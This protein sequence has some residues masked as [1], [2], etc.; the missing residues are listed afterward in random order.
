MLNNFVILT[1]EFKNRLQELTEAAQ[2]RA[3]KLRKGDINE[4]N[5]LQR[6]CESRIHSIAARLSQ[7]ID[8]AQQKAEKTR[9]SMIAEL[10]AGQAD[11]SNLKTQTGTDTDKQS[12][13]VSTRCLWNPFTWFNSPETVSYTVTRNYEYL[14]TADAI[15]QVVNYSRE[16]AARMEY[17]FRQVVSITTLRADLKRALL[18]ELD[19]G[20][21]GFDPAA[22]RTTFEGS[23]RQLKLPELV[24]NV[25]DAGQNISDCFNA[26]VRSH[27]MAALRQATQKALTGVYQRLSAEFTRKVTE[28][29]QRLQAMS[30]SL[31]QEMTKDLHKELN[32]LREAFANKEQELQSYEKLIALTQLF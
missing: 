4:L 2:S 7:V 26:K 1:Y 21:S 31:A 6:A 11:I 32:Q 16:S 18:A 17:G 22:F 13:E 29:C 24:L 12:R 5:S 3:A 25:G 20:S 10:Q 27:E 28:L 23:L 30:D 14:A 19:T 8:A 9:E 15:D